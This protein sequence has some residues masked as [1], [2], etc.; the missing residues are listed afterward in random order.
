M[1][2][3]VFFCGVIKHELLISKIDVSCFS[4]VSITTVLNDDIIF[5]LRACNDADGVFVVADSI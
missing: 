2:K 4:L 3:F 1:F 5:D